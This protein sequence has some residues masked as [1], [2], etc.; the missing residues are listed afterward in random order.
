MCGYAAADWGI[1]REGMFGRANTVAG[2]GL[3]LVGLA[4]SCG[5]GHGS[6]TPARLPHALGVR[7]AGQASAIEVSLTRGDMC[8]AARQ[9]AELGSAVRA[10]VA[11]GQVPGTLRAP[12]SE[13]V[14]SLA[15]RIRC[16][17]PPTKPAPAKKHGHEGGKPGHHGHGDGNGHGNGNGGDGGGD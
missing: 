9:A 17:P 11:A 7:L 10:A 2:L 8:T 4:V 14:R 12:L 1:L 6:A 3:A 13:S 15:S 16:V 5:G